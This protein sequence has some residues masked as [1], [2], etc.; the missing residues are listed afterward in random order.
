M[1]DLLETKGIEGTKVSAANE[2][3]KEDILTIG[4][5]EEGDE[6]WKIVIFIAFYKNFAK[7][8]LKFSQHN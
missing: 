6:S 8:M 2:K 3:I 5:L 4:D 7:K 1:S